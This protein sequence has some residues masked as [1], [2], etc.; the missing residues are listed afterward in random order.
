MTTT[1]PRTW[2]QCKLNAEVENACVSI[3][4][5]PE[6]PRAASF[7]LILLQSGH[8]VSDTLFPSCFWNK[9]IIQIETECHLMTQDKE[10]FYSNI[11]QGIISSQF[12]EGFLWIKPLTIM[13]FL[14]KILKWWIIL[15]MK[16][17]NATWP[18]IKTIW[19]CEI[20][21]KGYTLKVRLVAIIYKYRCRCHRWKVVEAPFKR[22][23]LCQEDMTTLPRTLNFSFTIV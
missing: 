11:L 13:I 22:G 20:N 15:W 16:S 21:N 12:L 19:S 9:D 17:P 10:F 23:H 4:T 18:L 8:V 14:N 5:Y 2:L 1:G 3:P 6:T 7:V